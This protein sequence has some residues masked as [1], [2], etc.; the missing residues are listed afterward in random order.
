MEKEDQIIAMLEKIIGKLDEH[1]EALDEHSSILSKHTSILNE[2]SS[3]LDKHTGILNEHSKKHEEHSE[4]FKEHG[5]ILAA[6]RNGQEYLKAEMDGMKIA[7]AKEFGSLKEEISLISTNQD[8]LRED[9]WASKVDIHRI[10][11]TMGMK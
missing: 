3:I 11:N 5:Q 9:T 4:Q 8:L 1:G 7:N 6:L 2:H 10:K